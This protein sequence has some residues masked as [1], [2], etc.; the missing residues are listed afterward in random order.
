MAVVFEIKTYLTPNGNDSGMSM[1]FIGLS[2][3]QRLTAQ[4]VYYD[5]MSTFGKHYGRDRDVFALGGDLYCNIKT[6]AQ[7]LALVLAMQKAGIFIGDPQN[8]KYEDGIPATVKL[9]IR[10]AVRELDDRKSALGR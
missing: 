4:D 8:Q 3:T 6:E 2:K 5:V 10:D 7:A 9:A 1:Y